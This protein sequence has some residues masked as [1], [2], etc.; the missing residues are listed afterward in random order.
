[1]ETN[2]QSKRYG[3]ILASVLILV[4]LAAGTFLSTEQFYTKFST[5][6]TPQH[7]DALQKTSRG[8]YTVNEL[9][10][11]HKKNEDKDRDLPITDVLFEGSNNDKV[12]S[13]D[14]EDQISIGKVVEESISNDDEVDENEVSNDETDDDL[15][16]IA[17]HIVDADDD[18]I[19]DMALERIHESI[20]KNNTSATTIPNSPACHPH[21]NLALPNN[22][23]SNSTGYTF[24]IREKQLDQPFINISERLQISMV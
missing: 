12:S 17:K 3:T 22:R 8:K 4:I 5:Q 24:I 7:Y 11:I 19:Y 21:F 23:W 16:S 6:G 20:Q 14:G 1:M 18:N 2:T 15:Y 10:N 9:N 13:G